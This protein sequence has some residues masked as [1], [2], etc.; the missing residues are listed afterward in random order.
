MMMRWLVIAVLI[1]SAKADAGTLKRA[2]RWAWRATEAA[3]IA[4]R[5]A[6]VRSSW[7]RQE[8]NPV[9]GRGTYGPRQAAIELGATAAALAVEEIAARRHPEARARF[10]AA[11]IGTAAVLGAVAARN[12][13]TK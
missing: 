4:G 11:N 8:L 12:A 3:L 6:D 2:P 7:G 10:A 13:G 1:A 9:L 5:A